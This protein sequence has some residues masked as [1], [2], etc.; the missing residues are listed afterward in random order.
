MQYLHAETK[1]INLAFH[2]PSSKGRWDSHV[3]RIQSSL[4]PRLSFSSHGS[5]GMR[6]IYNP[7]LTYSPVPLT[8][9]ALERTRQSPHQR[10][11]LMSDDTLN[12]ALI[13]ASVSEP[14]T[15]LFNCD[16]SWYSIIII[17]I[18]SVVRRA[19]TKQQLCVSSHLKNGLCQ[20]M[21]HSN[22]T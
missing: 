5:L 4:V 20:T 1:K 18:L 9:A 3:Y 19:E 10:V 22:G 6:L 16:F 13:G 15:S 2:K 7:K 11:S 12:Y 8:L 14:H 17:Y 21:W